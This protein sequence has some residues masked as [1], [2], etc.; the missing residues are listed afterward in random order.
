MT[1]A[2]VE[3]VKVLQGELQAANRLIAAHEATEAATADYIRALESA[4][5]ALLQL[6]YLREE[7]GR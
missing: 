1:P 7:V 5:R 4:N 2:E 6:T 3:W